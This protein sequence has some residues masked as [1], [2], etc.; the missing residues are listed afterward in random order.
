MREIHIESE[1]RLLISLSGS[2]HSLLLA[3]QVGL[4]QPFV[5]SVAESCCDPDALT[6]GQSGGV[7]I[8]VEDVPLILLA[9]EAALAQGAPGIEGG[10]W[11]FTRESGVSAVTSPSGVTVSV[12]ENQE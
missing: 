10:P 9:L 4:P 5:E 2:I 11:L 8:P 12:I 7:R 1:G 3:T 6:S